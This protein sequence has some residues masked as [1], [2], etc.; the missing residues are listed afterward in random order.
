MNIKE[1]KWSEIFYPISTDSIERL[2]YKEQSITIV[3]EMKNGMEAVSTG[4]FDKDQAFW[5]VKGNNF[6]VRDLNLNFE[7]SV[8]KIKEFANKCKGLKRDEI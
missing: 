1:M 5:L 3:H 6:D 2:D 7:D 8:A 4:Y